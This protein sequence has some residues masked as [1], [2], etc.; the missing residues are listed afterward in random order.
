LLIIHYEWNIMTGS[1]KR[2]KLLSLLLVLTAIFMLSASFSV[3]GNSGELPAGQEALLADN[4]LELED[5]Y[6][7]RLE[8]IIEPSIANYIQQCLDRASD[9]GYGLIIIMDTP[10]GLETSMRDIITRMLNVDIPVIVFVYPVGARA[11]SAGVF[12]SYAS[13]IAV[14]GPST[15]IGA[16]H[17]VNLGGEQEVSEDL[18]EKVTNDS[19]SYIKNLAQAR[20]RNEQWAEEAV[21]ESVSIT[22]EE[23]LEL[24]VIDYIAEDL[25]DLLV[26]IDGNTI[27][28]LGKT[29]NIKSAGVTPSEINMNFMTRFLHIISNP[30]IA[31]I[32]LSLGTL[33]II[34]EFSQPGLGI[35]GA[36]GALLLILGLYALSVL[37]INYAGLGLIILAIVL[38]VVDILM[39]LGGIP[40]IAGV[41][42]LIIGSFLLIN[43]DAPYLRVATSLIISVAVVVSGFL[44]IVVRAVYKAHRVK[45]VTGI[46]GIMDGTAIVSSTLKPHGQVK[47]SGEIWG[48]VSDTGKNIEKGKKVRIRSIEGLV[49]TVSE[50]KNK[51][52]EGE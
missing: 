3:S 36:V 29:Y 34:Y 15:N 8:G 42:S 13:D 5:F 27:E 9:S 39:A 4:V 10:G 26:K 11:A 47:I 1:R 50:I 45:P 2:I 41:I 28:K 14:M 43:T 19:V 40:S 17:P 52:K 38:F 30:N 32:L 23:A 7:C 22:A 12:I 31:Y 24:G 25:D 16:A 20:G 18:M 48:A 21:R 49:L 46:N 37:P 44:F 33:G 6:V 51:D 35:S